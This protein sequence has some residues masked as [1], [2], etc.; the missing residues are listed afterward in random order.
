[1]RVNGVVLRC[2]LLIAATAVSIP[3][4]PATEQPPSIPIDDYAF[5][6]QIVTKKFLTSE[7]RLVV[8]DRMT[9]A[10]LVPNQDGP[11]T[12]ELFA[13]QGYFNR[14]LPLDLVR[15]FVAMNQVPGRLEGRFQF[16]VR[17]R[18]M[19]GEAMEEPEVQAAIPVA[20]FRTPTRASPVVDRLAFSRVGRTQRND[21]ALVYVANLRPDGTGAGFLVWFRRQGREWILFDTEVAWT[22]R[23][24]ETEAPL[25]APY[26]R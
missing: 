8:L 21:G 22:V 7:T 3:W 18:F 4:L 9:V 23:E 25:L 17:Y 24:Q 19:S 6:D 11:I 13:E 16:P 20:T 10:R 1:M 15:D 2:A 26:G 12:V 14:E 5:Y